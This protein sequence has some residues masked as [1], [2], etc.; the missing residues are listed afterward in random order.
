MLLTVTCKRRTIY[1]NE[2]NYSNHQNMLPH[3]D[4]FNL[5]MK[6]LGFVLHLNTEHESHITSS[7]SLRARILSMPLIGR[8]VAIINLWRHED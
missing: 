4:N 3:F 5:R 2:S 6:N 1:S 7:L 8:Y